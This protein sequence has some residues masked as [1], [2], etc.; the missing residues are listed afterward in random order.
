LLNKENMKTIDV[1]NF[2]C[3]HLNLYDWT[4]D[5]EFTNWLPNHTPSN[6]EVSINCIIGQ[7]IDELNEML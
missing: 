4:N 3:I 6:Y 1:S 7:L 2:I 5:V